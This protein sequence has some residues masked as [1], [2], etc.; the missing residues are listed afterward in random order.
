M[1]LATTGFDDRLPRVPGYQSYIN[2]RRNI[3][4]ADDENLKYIPYL[5]DRK[6]KEQDKHHEKL[7]K[8]LE[9]AGANSKERDDKLYERAHKLRMWLISWLKVLNLNHLDLQS[10]KHYALTLPDTRRRVKKATGLES[11]RGRYSLDKYAK[12]IANRFSKAFREVFGIGIGKVVLPK[13]Q[14][15]EMID[16]AKRT[17]P[18]TSIPHRLSTYTDLTCMICGVVDCS[19]HGR[20][21]DD[22]SSDQDSN[23]KSSSYTAPRQHADI[24]LSYP[25]TLARYR[26]QR[27]TRHEVP[28]KNVGPCSEGCYMAI[29][30]EELQDRT[31]C[32]LEQETIDKIHDMMIA[33]DDPTYQSCHIAFCISIPCWQVHIEVAHYIANSNYLEARDRELET[34]T[35]A[36]AV[37]PVWYDNKRKTISRDMKD[38]TSAHIHETRLTSESVSCRAL[39]YVECLLLNIRSAVIK[40]LVTKHVHVQLGTYSAKGFV[41]VPMTAPGDLQAAHA[42]AMGLLAPRTIVYV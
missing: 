36:T 23:D 12:E 25:E 34:Q 7:K 4:S 28:L 21:T 13:E 20:F 27:R 39:R 38:A 26:T 3:L 29:F 15:K 22:E 6:E 10:L 41:L 32:E 37:R 30:D 1:V 14:L 8:E 18:S 2:V 33:M 9:N 42:M 5:G 11:L 24:A 17:R 35:H 19:T 16:A 40:D 31:E